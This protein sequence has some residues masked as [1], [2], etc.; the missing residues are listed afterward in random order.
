[1]GC[2]PI[3]KKGIASYPGSTAK[4]AGALIRLFPKHSTYSEPF[5]GLG[6]VFWEHALCGV[7]RVVIGEKD[8]KV[9]DVWRQIAD[10]RLRKQL[11][12]KQCIRANEKKLK[13][14]L[15]SKDALDRLAYSQMV[16]GSQ[17]LWPTIPKR[18]KGKD[19]CF[20]KLR[21]NLDTM[22]DKLEDVEL[23]QGDYE[24]TILEA[25][26]KDTF[27]FIDPPWPINPN[28]V[29]RYYRHWKMDWVRFIRILADIRGKFMSYTRWSD[30]VAG[31]AQRA[32]LRVY[33]VASRKR[34][35]SSDLERMPIDSREGYMLISNYKLPL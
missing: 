18:N 35:K 11:A 13:S 3:I 22:E 29:R 10:G 7:E 30:D 34:Y 23:M 4:S 25:D 32:G 19:F 28:D 16:F 8:P 12:R 14:L 17:I 5:A 33:R 21:R 9:L 2:R 15:N 31:K 6:A 24:D 1:M 27:H 26:S 20:A